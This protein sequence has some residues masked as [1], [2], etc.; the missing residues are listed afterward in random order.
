[1]STSSGNTRRAFGSG[2]RASCAT[3][4]CFA[5]FDGTP[6]REDEVRHCNRG[7]PD[8]GHANRWDGTRWQAVSGRMQHD[9]G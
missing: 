4:T 2:E 9:R 8:G 6:A 7:G 1:M 3:D 5:T